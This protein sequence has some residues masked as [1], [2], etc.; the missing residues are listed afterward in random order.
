MPTYVAGRVAEALNSAGKALRGSRVVV[1]GLSYKPGV[2]DV[3][4]SP[5]LAVLQHLVAGGAD[6][7]YHD[8]YVPSAVV[9]GRRA[10]DVVKAEEPVRLQSVPLDDEL[11]ASADCVVILTAH[12]E[13]DYDAVLER[14]PLVFD[15]VGATR[16]RRL[17]HVVL[18]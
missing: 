12:P 17:D 10:A 2:N 13:I 5:A 18:L 15:A 1:L 14:A 11:V 16:G 6:C 7:A 4:E 9:V 8:P 3:R